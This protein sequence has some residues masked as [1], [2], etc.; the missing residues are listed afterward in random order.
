MD[1][2]LD[3]T[4]NSNLIVNYIPLQL[5]EIQLRDMFAPF[6]TILTCKLVMDKMTHQSA[7]YG[8]VKFSND[9][10][11]ANALQALNGYAL[12]GKTL[13][14]SVAQPA[15]KKTDKNTVYL[16]GF[17]LEWTKNELERLA[18]SFGAVLESKIL[19]DPNGVSRGVGF[20]A[21]ESNE[22]ASLATNGLN[23]AT[24]PG[25]AKPLQAKLAQYSISEG[26]KNHLH[27]QQMQM[28]QQMNMMAA[29]G[30]GVPM[31]DM[32]KMKSQT[33]GKIPTAKNMTGFKSNSPYQ[34]PPSAPAA[35]GM[36]G[37][38]A[39]GMMNP[40]N[41]NP[42]MAPMGMGMDMMGN[43]NMGP[44]GAPGGVCLFI[45]HLPPTATEDQLLTLFSPYGTVSNV[46]VMRD[47]NTG[48]SKGFG[49]V[50]MAT[51]E[52]AQFAMSALNNY[53]WNGKR[54]RISIKTDKQ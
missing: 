48:A 32:S 9:Q 1:H 52:Q 38:D 45:Y 13:K 17:P 53:A 39:F 14:V 26:K 28:M 8:F 25:C 33:Y 2:G 29:M 31:M 20:I 44:G 18:S 30:M 12:M 46:K 23:N 5:S 21:L 49:F 22:A 3:G 40:M 41:M 43:M 36:M 6:G 51:P 16:A 35:P 47:L 42:M 24:P 19:L 37:I 15:A 4:P 34:R 10:E 54:L 50:N 11:A 27:K 7:G